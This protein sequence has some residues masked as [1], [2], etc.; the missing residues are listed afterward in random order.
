MLEQDVESEHHVSFQHLIDG[1]RQR[2]RQ[3]R[4]RLAL[5][6]CF[7]SASQIFVARR[8]VA[9]DQAR[10]FGEGPRERG[11]PGRRTGGTLTLPSRCLG[12]C[13][14]AAGGH[15]ILGPWNAGSIMEL[16]EQYQTHNRAKAGD[17][18]EPGQGLGVVRLGRRH[19]GQCDSAE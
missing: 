6:V 12:A 10:R 4:Q 1:P 14:Q 5:A 9:E 16:V 15:T 17:G 3:D 8:M 19:D 7:L 11:I 13:A 2:M 18:W